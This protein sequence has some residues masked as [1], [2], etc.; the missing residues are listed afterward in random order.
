MLRTFSLLSVVGLM[1][2]ASSAAAAEQK[3]AA[4]PDPV[5]AAFQ[6]YDVNHD[7]QLS[8]DEFTNFME[9]RKAKI[10]GLVKDKKVHGLFNLLDVDQSGSLSLAEF[11]RVT[12]LLKVKKTK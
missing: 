9:Q 8:R 4:K 12:E 10:E 5:T 2:L 6:K 3:K 11:K 1:A 7:G